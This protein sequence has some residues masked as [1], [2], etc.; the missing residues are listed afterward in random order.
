MVKTVMYS[1]AIATIGMLLIGM[2][3]FDAEARSF[4]K[5][6]AV[7][8][9]GNSFHV[10]GPPAN[11][12]ITPINDDIQNVKLTYKVMT[13]DGMKG[14]S[15]SDCTAPKQILKISAMKKATVEFDTS[16]LGCPNHKGDH[17][18]ISLSFELN[19][20]IDFQVY[21]DTNCEDIGEGIEECTRIHGNSNE[22]FGVVSGTVFGESL[23]PDI[24]GT[25]NTINERR[26]LW[27]TP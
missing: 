24:S 18:V 17:G 5:G 23:E 25:I 14:K 1:A 4:D 9:I 6:H 27:T 12:F 8:L 11:V 20:E 19:G 3:A 2:M 10:G 7:N 21:D 15:G 26:V 13:S 16:D 22:A